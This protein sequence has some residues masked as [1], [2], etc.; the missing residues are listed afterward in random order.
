M[1]SDDPERR[2]T[3][4]RHHWEQVYA[5]RATDAVSWFQPHAERSLKLI[6]ETGIARDAPII[7]IG[8][9]ASRLVDDLLADG[10]TDV[11]VLDISAAALAAA[12]Q[13]IGARADRVRWIEADIRDAALP[14]ATYALWHD[15]AA[16]HFLTDADDRRAYVDSARR[17]IRPGGHVV[18]ATF[19]DDGPTRCS[20][21]PVVRYDADGI[22]REFGDGF[23]LMHHEREMHRTPAGATQSFLFCRLQRTN[24]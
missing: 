24:E 19:A 22:A 1:T 5:T 10:W 23:R 2:S 16:F 21:L 14:E 4:T 8:G 17:A 6:R 12:R 20:G 3:E 15:R 9:G 11:T 18:I 13:R 7:D